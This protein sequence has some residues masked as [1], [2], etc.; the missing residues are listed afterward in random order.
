ME[1]VM[2]VRHLMNH[3]AGFYYAFTNSNCLNFLGALNIPLLADSEEFV[4]APARLPLIHHPERDI[5]MD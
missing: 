3:T 5:T 2:T 4:K 1:T